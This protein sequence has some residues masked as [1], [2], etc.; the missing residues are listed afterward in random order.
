MPAKAPL[1]LRIF[2]SSPGDVGDERR[3]ARQIIDAL[4]REPAYRGK[5]IGRAHV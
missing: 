3:L 2:I 5:K 1:H 4:P